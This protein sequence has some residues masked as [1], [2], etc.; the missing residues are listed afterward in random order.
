MNAIDQAP[1]HL[2]LGR[3]AETLVCR[4]L[5][6][7]FWRIMARNWVGGGGELDVVA[8]RWQTLLVGEVRYRADGTAFTSIDRDKLD[9]TLAAA[10]SMIRSHHL[11]AYRL[12]VDLFGLDPRWRITR[13]RDVTR[14]GIAGR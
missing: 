13:H 11:E 2:V 12:R 4:H 6:W 8:V 5:R 14:E 1:E 3:R 9:R 10:R 7:R